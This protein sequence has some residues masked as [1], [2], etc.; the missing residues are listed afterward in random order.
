MDNIKLLTGKRTKFTDNNPDLDHHRGKAPKS[1]IVQI[2][3]YI[4]IYIVFDAGL[5]KPDYWHS[6]FFH[7]GFS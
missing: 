4:Y 3:I 2:Y 6:Y 1:F 5:L 7:V